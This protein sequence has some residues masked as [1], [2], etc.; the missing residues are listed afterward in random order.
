MVQTSTN[1]PKEVRANRSSLPAWIGGTVIGV[2]L[3]IAFWAG[4]QYWPSQGGVTAPSGPA[5]ITLMPNTKGVPLFE[6]SIAD[7]AQK[8]SEAVVNID[9]SRNVTVPDMSM[10]FH[11]FFG[12]GA[13]PFGGTRKYQQRGSGSGFILRSDGY[14]LTNNHVAGQADDIKVTLNDKREFKG[15]VVGRDK[16]TDLAL[17]KID[18]RDLPVARM[19][20]SKD[21]R[22]GDFSIAIGSP[23]GLDHSVTMGIISALGRS[24]SNGGGVEF[25][26]TDT[27]INPGNSGG[28][29]LNLRGEVIGI[30]TAIRGDAQNIGFAIPID[31]AREVSDQLLKHGSIQRP[32]VGVY[33][34]ELQPK[35]ARSLGLPESTKGVL[36]AKVEAGSPAEQGQ[37]TAGDVILKVDGKPVTTS[38]EV[39]TMVRQ[40]KVGEELNMIIMRDG[41]MTSITV[42]LGTYPDKEE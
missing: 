19:G 33:M 28:P 41:Q 34:S 24:I 10:P 25:I 13:D 40:H 21:L 22:A 8:A 3:S 29:L 7:V 35:V 18:A 15:K 42:K 11:F 36:V 14:I 26:Q 31:L 39:Q 9:I 30:N 17:V 27:A 23:L 37:L 4:H 2:A 32:Y 20:T 6:N 38:K 12:Q 16:Y 5:P 1:S